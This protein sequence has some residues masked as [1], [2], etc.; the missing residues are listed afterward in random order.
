MRQFPVKEIPAVG[1]A[2]SNKLKST[3]ALISNNA[4]PRQSWRAHVPFKPIF[5]SGSLLNSKF[6]RD[7]SR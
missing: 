2:G 5:L 4:A 7:A 1:A 3:I 6:F